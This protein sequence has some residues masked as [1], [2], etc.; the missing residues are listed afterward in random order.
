[1]RFKTLLVS[2][3][4]A[5][6]ILWSSAALAADGAGMADRLAVAKPLALTEFNALNIRNV[7]PEK[8][9]GAVYFI[10]GLDPSTHA[11]EDFTP[12]YPYLQTLNARFGWDV[13]NAK[14]P[15]SEP[16]VAHSIPRSLD[17]VGKRIAALKAQ[18]YKKVVIAG[19]SWGAWLSINAASLQD[20]SKDL[21][22]LLIV[23]PAAY[24]SRIWNGKNNPYYLQN[25]TDYVRHIKAVRTPTVAVFFDGD[26]YDP[27]ERGD[28]TDAFYRRTQTPLLLIDRP[29]GFIGHGAGWLPPFADRFAFC[30]DG[31]FRSPATKACPAAD[32]KSHVDDGE[33][34]EAQL[35]GDRNVTPVKQADLA[36]RQFILTSPQIE[37]RVLKFG[38]SNVEVAAADGVFDADL[39]KK[40]NETCLGDECFRLY[41]L[42]DNRYVGFRDNGSFAGWLTPIR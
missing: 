8:A 24:G 13:V 27:G 11:A 2:L 37:V 4:W 14:Y 32:P 41:R 40:D 38:S 36:G 35:V 28:I 19:Q 1:M 22:G 15:D 16:D 7:G 26:A 5:C 10:D 33:P 29:T 42:S 30:I 23:A 34:S 17:F 25:L 6:A 21:D 9:Y 3:L 39:P 20:V 18:G 31:F 12:T